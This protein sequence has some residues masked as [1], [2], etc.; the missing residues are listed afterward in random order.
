MGTI[1]VKYFGQANEGCLFKHKKLYHIF[2][3]YFEAFIYNELLKIVLK[4]ITLSTMYSILAQKFSY[5]KG[6]G[7]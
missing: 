6:K 4:L 5:Q 3:W 1:H 7:A 2:Y